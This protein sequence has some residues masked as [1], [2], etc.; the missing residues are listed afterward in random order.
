MAP[1]LQVRSQVQTSWFLCGDQSP[2]GQASCACVFVLCPNGY[3]PI[4]LVSFNIRHSSI[5]DVCWIHL[6]STFDVAVRR[7]LIVCM[8]TPIVQ[9]LSFYL[10]H[11]TFPPSSRFLF[12][13]CSSVGCCC[14]CCCYAIGQCVHPYRHGSVNIWETIIE[15]EKFGH[16]RWSLFK[17][18]SVCCCSN[19]Q[20]IR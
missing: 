9:S 20:F 18:F 13:L 8:W 16:W 4:S 11:L 2:C 15:I 6:F 5:P 12:S 17:L 10:R 14:C 7:M 3:C 19:H 1:P